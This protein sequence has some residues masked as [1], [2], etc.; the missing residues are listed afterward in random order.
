[1]F[2]LGVFK[3]VLT[4]YTVDF[5]LTDFLLFSLACYELYM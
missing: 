5:L 1:M 2:I 3:K 4:L